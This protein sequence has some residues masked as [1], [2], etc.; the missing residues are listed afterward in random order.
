MFI[1]SY[2]ID[3][4]FNGCISGKYF[5]PIFSLSS[6]YLWYKIQRFLHKH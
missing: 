1:L 5:K 6:G 4:F 2:N 3:F